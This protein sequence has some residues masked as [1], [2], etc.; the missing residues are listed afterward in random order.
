MQVSTSSTG[1]MDVRAIQ[2]LRNHPMRVADFGDRLTHKTT[3][4]LGPLADPNPI[5]TFHMRLNSPGAFAVLS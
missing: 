5:Q 4:I 2:R 1:R 3:R